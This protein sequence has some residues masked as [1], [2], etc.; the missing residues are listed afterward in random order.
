MFWKGPEILREETPAQPRLLVKE[1]EVLKCA[2]ISSNQ[3][4]HFSE[5]IIDFSGTR[6]VNDVLDRVDDPLGLQENIVLEP[7]V[8][9]GMGVVEER[10]CVVQELQGGFHF[11]P[12]HA[13]VPRCLL[14]TRQQQVR[15]LACS[16][17]LFAAVVLS[18]LND[19]ML[20]RSQSDRGLTV[21]LVSANGGDAFEHRVAAGH[22]H[23]EL[24][25]D[26]R[27]LHD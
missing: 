3:R 24:R 12:V 22:F 13:A 18:E 23:P 14:Q 25:E 27:L 1:S 16:A 4:T 20:P 8:E 15:C 21:C 11:L 2:S 9:S 7:S 5:L 10:P 26:C 6:V 17:Q 19:L